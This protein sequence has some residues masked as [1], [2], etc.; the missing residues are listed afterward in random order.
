M[1]NFNITIFCTVCIFLPGQVLVVSA[2]MQVQKQNSNSL[3]PIP[4]NVEPNI[5]ANVNLITTGSVEVPYLDQVSSPGQQ[6][7]EVNPTLN[8]GTEKTTINL[9]NNQSDTHSIP[10]GIILW[11]LALLIGG[12][13]FWFYSSSFLK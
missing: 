9:D 6:G 1:K 2:M 13:W 12:V 10:Y 4:K 8:N 7:Q 5:S 11:A 3:Q